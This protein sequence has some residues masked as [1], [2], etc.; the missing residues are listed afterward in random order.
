MRESDIGRAER[1]GPPVPEHGPVGRTVSPRLIGRDAE[2]EQAAATAVRSPA[3]VVIE[4]E[5]GIG[6]TRLLTELRARPELAGLR[7]VTGACRPIRDPFPLGVVVDA[8][9]GQAGQLRAG[10]LR[11][12]QLTAVTGAL[13]PLLLEL[14]D[15]LPPQPEPLDDRIAERHRVFRGLVELLDV[16][17][18]AVIALED[19]HWADEQTLDF[20]QYLLADPRPGL[21]VVLTYRGEEVASELRASIARLPASTSRAHLVLEPLDVAETGA[22]GAAILDTDGLSEAF[23]ANLCE[24]ASG[25]PFA[26]EELLALLRAR[27]TLVR[28]DDGWSRRAI[29]ELEVPAGIRDSV[30]ERVSRL[31]ELA[32]TV[33]DAAAVLQTSM[34]LQVLTEV[35]SLPRST[36]L[37]GLDDA[38]AAGLLVERD[39]NVGFRHVLAAQA[40]YEGLS[41]PRRVELHGRAATVLH[42]LRPAP[43]GQVAHHLRQAGRLEAWAAVAEQAAD[44]ALELGH[45]DEAV[46]LLHDV[47]HN[48]PLEPGHQGRL[49]GALGLAAMQAVRTSEAFDLLSEILDAKYDRLPRVVRGELRFWLAMLL[50]TDGNDAERQYRLWSEAVQDLAERPDLSAWAMTLLAMPITPGVAMAEHLD[51]LWR[52]RQSLAEVDNPTLEVFL[53]GKAAMVLTLVGDPDWRELADRMDHLTSGAP[54]N[55][56][57]VSAYYSV[58]LDACYAGHHDAAEGLLAAGL[59]GAARCGSPRPE[60]RVRSARALLDYCT[61]AWQD[62]DAE[63]AVVREKLNDDWLYW[64]DATVVTGC[65]ALARGRFDEAERWLLEVVRDS[66]PIEGDLLPL[67]TAA[68]VRLALA[69]RDTETAVGAAERFLARL[70]AKPMW[71]PAVRALPPMVAAMVA[72]GR[73]ADAGAQVTRFTAELDALDAPL[74]APMLAH[75]RGILAQAG[76]DHRSA[77]AHFLSAAGLYDASRC[78]YEAAQVREEAA[79]CLFEIGDPGAVEVL[80]IAISAYE[81]LGARWDLDRSISLAR[82]RGARLPRYRGGTRG[83]GAELSPRELE[84][85]RLAAMDCTNKEIAERLYVSHNTVKKQLASAMRKLGVTSRTALARRLAQDQAG[86]A[87]TGHS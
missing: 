8:L 14:D 9:R 66:D 34:P 76:D 54:R 65:L 38:L 35:T 69:R 22:L 85:A 48:A 11:A 32:R 72:A 83:Y 15:V 10:Q 59:R 61:G 84:V 45:D 78:A 26:I 64:A 42:R 36:A 19:L 20:L 43:L 40:V 70:D 77:T 21:T 82:A 68:V 50:H 18:P 55:R 2:L 47:L 13:R 30:L 33:L 41:L 51:W 39:G 25:V 17:G 79:G 80:T 12:G 3:V 5:A 56:R 16:L 86:M 29:D 58:G 23:A 37:A 7:F 63:L 60:M 27:G 4:G 53:L 28:R 81:A 71:P 62:L 31:T 1:S 44:Q 74:A 24:R 6:K 87:R 49:A 67:R 52:A 73:V 46:R 75:A 57:E